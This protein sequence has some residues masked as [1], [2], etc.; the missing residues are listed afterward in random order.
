MSEKNNIN[1]KQKSNTRTWMNM[2]EQ[3]FDFP[4]VLN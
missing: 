2:D 4:S 3:H 1:Q